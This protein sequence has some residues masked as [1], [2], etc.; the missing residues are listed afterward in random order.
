MNSGDWES[1]E[2]IHTAWKQML[3][4]GL[5]GSW[6]EGA[7]VTITAFLIARLLLVVF[8]QRSDWLTRCAILKSKTC[9]GAPA[10][11]V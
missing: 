3:W 2:G 6:R 11:W 8:S 7:L 1:V 5:D 10:A 9:S 4:F